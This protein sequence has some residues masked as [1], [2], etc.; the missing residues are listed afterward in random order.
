MHRYLHKSCVFETVST[1]NVEAVSAYK[2]KNMLIGAADSGLDVLSERANPPTAAACRMRDRIASLEML[3]SVGVLPH[4]ISSRADCDGA[5]SSRN[6]GAQS[7]R[8]RGATSQAFAFSDDQ[9]PPGMPAGILVLPHEELGV[10]FGCLSGA[11]SCRCAAPE[12]PARPMSR[13]HP[14]PGF[15]FCVLGHP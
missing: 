15:P 12:R 2:H 11:L 13:L 7:Y 6:D 9:F 4:V 5:T 14:V 3:P 1:F 10:S 8:K